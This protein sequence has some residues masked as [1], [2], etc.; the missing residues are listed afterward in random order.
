MEYKSISAVSFNVGNDIYVYDRYSNEFL[1]ID[2]I[3]EKILDDTYNVS[4]EPA[5]YMYDSDAV[6]KR[7]KEIESA[8]TDNDVLK[9]F[10]IQKCQFQKIKQ[11]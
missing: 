3:T 5:N 4:F 7:Y 9:P 11:H 6:L 2:E 1:N 8:K 10:V